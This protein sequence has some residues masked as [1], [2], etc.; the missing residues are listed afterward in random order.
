MENHS[1]APDP[2]IRSHLA[3]IDVGTKGADRHALVLI[4]TVGY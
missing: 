2:G 1:D 3:Y 4:H